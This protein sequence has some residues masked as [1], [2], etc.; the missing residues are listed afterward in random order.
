MEICHLSYI[1]PSNDEEVREAA[2]LHPCY[3]DIFLFE[4][5]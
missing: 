5:P 4:P 3:F 2:S 1:A